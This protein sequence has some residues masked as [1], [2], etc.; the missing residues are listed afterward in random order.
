MLTERQIRR[1]LD[2]LEYKTV[3]TSPSGGRTRL[4][5]RVMGYSKEPEV[6]RI[7]GVL[8]IMLEASVKA[9]AP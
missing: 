3:Y 1:I 5:K 7:Q 8:S 4:Q 9:T 6:C 2:E